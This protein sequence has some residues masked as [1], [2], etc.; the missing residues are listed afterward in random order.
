MLWLCRDTLPCFIISYL[1]VIVSEN[2]NTET[3]CIGDSSD[4]IHWRPL[5]LVVKGWHEDFQHKYLAAA[6]VS[7]SFPFSDCLGRSV[8]VDGNRRR[9]NLSVPAVH[10]AKQSFEHLYHTADCQF[11]LESDFLQR[12]SISFCFF[13]AANTLDLSLLDDSVVSQGQSA[14]C[15]TPNPISTLAF[16]CRIPKPRRLV[17]ESVTIVHLRGKEYRLATYLGVKAVKIADGEII[18][19][20]GR[21]TLTIR[22]HN[23]SGHPLRAP[24]GGA[25]V[26]TIHEH[27]ACRV[28][29]VFEED[30]VPLLVL[31]APNAA[32]E[33]EY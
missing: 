20:Q 32:F 29:Y 6:S 7:S 3:V 26:R 31:D 17:S 8:C 22:P 30:G 11:L 14:C 9:K 2:E 27:P 1:R 10:R 18:V 33:Y 16:L 5:G 25:M 13:L 19:R 15:E 21:F 23:H 24:V 12:A 28:S 4:A